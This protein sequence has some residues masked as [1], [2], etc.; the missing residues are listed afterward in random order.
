MTRNGLKPYVEGMEIEVSPE[1]EDEG[2][3]IE[4]PR[5]LSLISVPL[6]GL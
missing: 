1:P 5:H 4:T 3:I 6:I 2:S